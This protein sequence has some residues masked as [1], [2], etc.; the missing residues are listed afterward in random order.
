MCAL[1]LHSIWMFSFVNQTQPR[2][3]AIMNMGSW[4]GEVR[5]R[6]YTCSFTSHEV[7]LYRLYEKCT[8]WKNDHC[9]KTTCQLRARRVLKLFNDVLLRTRRALSPYTL[10]SDS[11]ILVLNGTSLNIVNALLALNL[12]NIAFQTMIREYAVKVQTSLAIRMSWLRP[13]ACWFTQTYCARAGQCFSR[14]FRVHYAKSHVQPCQ[15]ENLQAKFTKAWTAFLGSTDNGTVF[16]HVNHVVTFDFT[17]TMLR[18]LLLK[19]FHY[20]I[21][22]AHKQKCLN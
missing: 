20:S 3:K 14:P 4:L 9:P 6:S 12:T 5:V 19:C 18:V 15:Y 13:P 21:L 11:A 22:F 16:E 1:F 8:L 2:V 7:M 10:Y 17:P